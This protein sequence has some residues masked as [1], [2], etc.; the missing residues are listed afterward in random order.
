[1]RSFYEWLGKQVDREDIVGSFAYTIRQYEEPQEEKR[2]R[3]K[4]HYKWATWL[5]DQ[6][7]SWEVINAFNITWKVYQHE[8][9]A[10]KP[11]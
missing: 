9:E 7:A 5:V 8:K 11:S 2:Y 6:K 1:M 4:E 3:G 10:K